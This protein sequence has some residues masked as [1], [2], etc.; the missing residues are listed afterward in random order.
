MDRMG[1]EWLMLILLSTWLLE[2][3]DVVLILWPLQ[4]TAIRTRPQTGIRTSSA[5]IKCGVCVCVCACVRV[6]VCAYAAVAVGP[7]STNCNGWMDISHDNIRMSNIMLLLRNCRVC[8]PLPL[9]MQ[10]HCWHCKLVSI[11]SRWARHWQC[12][13]DCYTRTDSCTGVC[14]CVWIVSCNLPAVIPGPLAKPCQ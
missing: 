5:Y 3:P 2:L 11:S 12:C 10:T 9:R 7:L 4:H 1:L 6:C 8:L 14:V 13:S